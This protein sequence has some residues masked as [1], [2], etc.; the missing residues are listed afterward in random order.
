MTTDAPVNNKQIATTP[1]TILLPDGATLRS[2][3]TCDLAIPGL[4]PEATKAH[5]VPGLA[6]TSLLSTAVLCDAGYQV[7]YDAAACHLHDGPRHILTGTRNATTGLWHFPLAST[8]DTPTNA[9]TPS[10]AP[11]NTPTPSYTA[12][13]VHTITY[14]RNRVKFMHQAFFCPPI[15]TLLRAANLGFLDNI[16]FLTPDLIHTHLGKSP[17]TAKG[18]L[19]LRPTGHLS[20]RRP[21]NNI[22]TNQKHAAAHVFCYAALADKQANTFYTDCTGNLPACTL[23][24]QQLFFVAYAYDPNYIF[25]VAIKS[26]TTKDI[27]DTF[28]GVYNRLDTHGFKP[29]FAVADNQAA[30]AIKAFIT[31][32]GGQVQFVEPNNHRA[33]AAERAIQTFKNHFISGLCTTDENFPLQ[34]WNHLTVQAEI[35]CN[36]LRRSRLNPTISAYE[37]LH[38]HKYNW[39]AH[40]LA[41]PG[42]RAVIHVSPAVRTSWGPR[43][44]DAWYCGP[45]LDHYQCHHFYVPETRAMRISGTYELYPQHCDLPIL[46][47][48][49]HLHQVIR[50]LLRGMIQL[51][52]RKRRKFF[53]A[54]MEALH[55]LTKHGAP[56][57]GPYNDDSLPWPTSKGE[58]EM[59]PTAKPTQPP[60]S[61]NPTAPH[62]AWT[63]PRLHMRQT[64]A[65]TAPTNIP[66]AIPT[67]AHTPPALPG[68]LPA[69]PTPELPMPHPPRRSPRLALI[70]PRRYCHAAL[71]A[72]T[73]QLNIPATHF[74]APVIHP[75]TGV[76]IDKYTT[77]I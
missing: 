66:T 74:C 26:T 47:P 4:R 45:A 10:N 68:L 36:I 56:K 58:R 17:A 19:K 21:H 67:G 32:H 50:E 5:I 15:Q 46:T 72:L 53:L 51:P 33:N 69:E 39:N 70:T 8:S 37:Q 73:A 22:P 71:A 42:T 57:E 11:T 18:R 61:T 12:N 6:H 49:Q 65:N 28:T 75:I 29:M 7:T 52:L 59:H 60:T 23:D 16:P 14:L 24:G 3:H 44:V 41:P 9:H 48:Q 27:M 38:G 2:T 30:P 31:A 63:A 77:L 40:P 13:N 62:I 55:A 54:L 34:L 64:R 1:I 43:G 35:T 25:A 20:T 76:S